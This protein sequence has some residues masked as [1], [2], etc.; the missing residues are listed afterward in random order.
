MSAINIKLGIERGAAADGK[1]FELGL[2]RKTAAAAAK[3]DAMMRN[4][5]AL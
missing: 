4:G 5:K 1:N 3:V 2:K